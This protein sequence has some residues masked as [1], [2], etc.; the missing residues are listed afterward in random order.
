[1]VESDM[2]ITWSVAVKLHMQ[3]FFSWSVRSFP[4]L[5]YLPA[6]S[7]GNCITSMTRIL[8]RFT[9]V[10]KIKDRHRNQD[11]GFTMKNNLEWCDSQDYTV[12]SQKVGPYWFLRKNLDSAN[13]KTPFLKEC[14]WYIKNLLP[15]T[16]C[17]IS[18]EG[19]YSIK[20]FRL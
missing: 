3:S 9:N 5:F 7:T 2:L 19:E 15:K 18:A 11:G 6:K 10:L 14:G 13:Y 20:V 4:C 17:Q 1:M 8:R 16:W 12:Q